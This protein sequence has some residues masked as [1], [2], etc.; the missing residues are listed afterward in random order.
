MIKLFSYGISGN[1]YLWIEA[2]LTNRSQ[3]VKINSFLSTPCPVSSGVPQGSVLGPLLFCCFINDVTDQLDPTAS[4]KLFA[5]DIKLYTSFSNIAPSIL[6]SQ[7]DIIQ[8]WS[9]LWQLRISHSKCNILTIGPHQQ[10]TNFVIDNIHIAQAD[11]VCDLGVTIDSQLKFRKHI[12]NIV[13]KANQRKSLIL[14]SF[15]SR[16]PANLIR[17]FKVYIRPL[18]EY[19]STTWS[20]SFITDILLLESVQRDFTKRVPGCSHLSYTERLSFLKLPTLEHRRLMADLIMV[21]NILT[22]NTFINNSPFTLNPNNH[23]RGHPLKLSVPITKTNTHKSIFFNRI[24]P[25]WNSLPADIVLSNNTTSFRYKLKAIDLN[26]HLVFPS[27]I[28]D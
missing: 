16:N 13:S 7:L 1:L 24:I 17:A 20:P 26:R 6:Q 22:H 10:P 14:R 23:L 21:Y 12:S 8:S 11:H 2:F 5:D 25:I 15:L 9:S 19:A 27:I 28:F 3:S 4:T 18:L